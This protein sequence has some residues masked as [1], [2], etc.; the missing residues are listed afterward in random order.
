MNEEIKLNATLALAV[1]KSLKENN[2][3]TE[4][5]DKYGMINY[6]FSEEELGLVKILVL[7]SITAGDLEKLEKIPNLEKLVVHNDLNEKDKNGEELSITAREVEKIERC[8]NLKSLIIIGQKGMKTFDVSNMKSL[9]FLKISNNPDLVKIDGVDQLSG[10]LSFQIYGNQKLNTIEKLNTAIK[11]SK[12]L[13]NLVLDS[14]LF[15]DVINYEPRT[16]EFD[17]EVYLDLKN[18]KTLYFEEIFEMNR[19]IDLSLEQMVLMHNKA[20]EI[21]S[22]NIQENANKRDVVVAAEIYLTRNVVY[23]DEALEHKHNYNDDEQCQVTPSRFRYANSPMHSAS[24]AYNAFM[25]NQCLCE[26]YTCAMQYLLKLRGILSYIVYTKLSKERFII[27][28]KLHDELFEKLE[29]DREE[30][31]SILSVVDLKNLYSD[32]CL[33]A[34]AYKK[35]DKVMPFMLKT[36]NEME[37]THEF[38][39]DESDIQNR[40]LGLSEYELKS[41]IRSCENAIESKDRMES[42]D[43]SNTKIKGKILI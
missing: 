39:S 31:H 5:I 38:I 21:L 18:I 36:K 27:D 12:C 8:K 42:Q 3:I 43:S 4:K 20:C 10:L 35:C 32:P 22:E 1:A 34:R 7:N 11:N 19:T 40:Y 29:L 25:Y 9:E 23:D 41:A 15:P 16:G 28:G 2:G 17:H 14:V 26:G 37:I 33:N 13:S 24:G 6:S 30:F